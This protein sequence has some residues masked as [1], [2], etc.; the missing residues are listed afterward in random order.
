[1]ESIG[2]TLAGSGPPEDLKDDGQ[3]KLFPSVVNPSGLGAQG[4]KD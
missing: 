1:M 3:Y 2:A 4:E